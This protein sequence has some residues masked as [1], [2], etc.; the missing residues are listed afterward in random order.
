MDE[1]SLNSYL[2]KCDDKKLV[3]CKN[4]NMQLKLYCEEVQEANLEEVEGVDGSQKVYALVAHTGK[5]M[6]PV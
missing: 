5:T 4:K 1:F 6:H 3:L 2:V